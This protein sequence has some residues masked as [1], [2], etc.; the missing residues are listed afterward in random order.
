ME[1]S[2]RGCHFNRGWEKFVIPIVITVLSLIRRSLNHSLELSGNTRHP[3]QTGHRL[4]ET[5]RGRSGQDVWLR[6]RVLGWDAHP[7]AEDQ[8]KALGAF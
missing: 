3:R 2:V 7:L 1:L 6:R 5:K 8:T 4:G